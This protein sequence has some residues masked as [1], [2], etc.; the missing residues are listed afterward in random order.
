MGEVVDI[1]PAAIRL[2]KRRPRLD[3]AERALLR[4]AKLLV[5]ATEQLIV[6][7]IV[8]LHDRRSSPLQ[9]DEACHALP[10]L[11]ELLRDRRTQLRQLERALLGTGRTG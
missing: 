2:R 10:L 5:Q 1:S 9:V 6:Q 4:T 3:E 11:D 8:M 7:Q